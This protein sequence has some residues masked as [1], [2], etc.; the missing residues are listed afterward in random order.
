M[1]VRKDPRPAGVA[2]GIY[3][4]RVVWLMVSFSARPDQLIRSGDRI[5]IF[6]NYDLRFTIYDLGKKGI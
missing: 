5:K 4:G 3:K 6:L 2:R 1:A